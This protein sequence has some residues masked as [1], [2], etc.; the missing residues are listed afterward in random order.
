MAKGLFFEEMEIGITIKHPITRTVT[1]MDNV[2]FSSLTF[3]PQPLHI[4]FDWSEKS[5]WGKPL[6]NSLFTLG[7]MIGLSVHDTTFQTTVANLGMNDVNFPA[8]LFHGDTVRVE[9]E[10][11][12]KRESK[13]K[14]DRGIVEFEHRAYNQESVLVAQCRRF[15][16]IY[17]KPEA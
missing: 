17:K 8:P 2:M 14:P 4:D 13:S 16:M 5:E 15:A 1:E 6:V 10:I 3:N 12:S 11:I 9:T 7:L